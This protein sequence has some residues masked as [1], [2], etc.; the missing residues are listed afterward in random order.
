LCV[1]RFGKIGI[2]RNGDEQEAGT[3][4]ERTISRCHAPATDGVAAVRISTDPLPAA[5]RIPFLREEVGRSLLR[6]D[7]AP[8]RDRSFRGEAMLRALPGLRA[9]IITTSES[10]LQRTPENIQDGNDDFGLV[11]SL[12]GKFTAFQR[13][14]DVPLEPGDVIPIASGEPGGL[15]HAGASFLG[16][17]LPLAALSPLVPNINDTF[18]RLIPRDHEAVRLLRRYLAALME[19]SAGTTPEFGALVVTHIRDLIALAVGARGEA[20]VD[21]AGRGLRAARIYAIKSDILANLEDRG[22]S[23]DIVAKRQHITPRY[24]HMLFEGEG[25]TFSQFVL[26]ARLALAHRMLSDGRNFYL[27]ISVVA[28]AAGFADLSHFNH[29]FRRRFGATPTDVRSRHRS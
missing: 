10:T 19:D 28:Y 5:Q 24:V 21:A 4:I 15:R 13:G 18:I 8:A 26:S 16:L 7:I 20:A 6:L 17:A 29:C 11:I 1:H 9:S 12:S 25:I 2:G 14:R 27:S 3:A 22:L 23:V